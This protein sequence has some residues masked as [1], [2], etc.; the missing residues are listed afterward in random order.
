MKFFLYKIFGKGCLA[1]VFTVMQD[2]LDK[3]LPIAFVQAPLRIL[4][5]FLQPGFV[6]IFY[7]GSYNLGFYAGSYN[8]VFQLLFIVSICF[9]NIF[10]LPIY[11]SL[12]YDF[13][14][15]SAV[16]M[17]LNISFSFLLGF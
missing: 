8:L 16:N 17:F 13:Y 15:I 12:I 6:F 3:G 2:R 7:A 11:I 10:A 14:D 4:C 5:W 1:F 9:K